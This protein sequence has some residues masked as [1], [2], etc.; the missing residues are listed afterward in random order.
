MIGRTRVQRAAL[1]AL[2]LVLAP[3]RLFAITAAQWQSDLQ[4]MASQLQKVH[5]NLFFQI[6]PQDF[7]A[8]VNGLNQQIPQ[9]SD[10]QIIVGLMKIAALPGDAHTNLWSPFEVMPIGLRWFSDGLFVV[11]AAQDYQRALGAKVVQ[12][13]GMTTDQAYDA[14]AAVISHENDQWVREV[15]ASYLRSPE[16]LY[17][18]GIIPV[19]GPIPFVFQDMTGAQF[20]LDIAPSSSA[21]VEAPDPTNGFIPLWLQNQYQYYRFQYLPSTNTIY[22]AYNSCQN[23]YDLSFASF[24]AQVAASVE[25]HPGASLVVDL[26]NNE[27]GNSAVMQ[28]LLD[29]LNSNT[30]LEGKL[31]VVIGRRTFSSA[32]IN[33]ITLANQYGAALI[34]EP[35][36]GSPNG[37]GNVTSFMLRNSGLVVYC[38]TKQFIMVPGDNS[39]SVMPNVTISMST[40]DYFARHDPFLIAALTLPA[41]YQTPQAGS[42]SPATVNAASFGAPVSPG[43]LATVFG[44]FTGVSPATASGMPLEPDLA[45]VKVSVNG[46]AA[47]LLG[48]WATQINFQV[49]GGTAAGTTQIAI[50]VPGQNP[51]TGTMQVVSSSPGIFL[52]DFGS[53][54]RPAAVLT[55]GYQL[56]TSTVRAERNGLIQIF[57]TGAGPLTVP[58]ADGAAA[59]FSP[60]AETTLLPRVFVGSEEAV[61]KF[62]GLA[63]GFAGL[64]QIDAL[65]PDAASITGEAPLVVVAPGGYASNGVTIWVE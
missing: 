65:L 44:D 46:V 2:L 58:V 36:G 29:M 61:V 31:R 49:P 24:M 52:R 35:S 45:G 42:G 6:S 60:L 15:S 56:I 16:I 21:I 39:P 33:T 11:S 54:D 25:Q 40:A 53:L 13:G 28:P 38:A 43:G 9:L 62:S 59:P 14:V 51:V 12:I 37:Y 20:E 1:A 26:R 5:P 8:A 27:G 10:D 17:G 4:Y 7:N 55:A 47:P 34:G 30:G 19:V 48:V 22:L 50:S 32:I 64:W 18:L 41:Q 63:P 3:A 23:D 57:G